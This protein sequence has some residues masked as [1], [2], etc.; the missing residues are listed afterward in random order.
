M[1][2]KYIFHENPDFCKKVYKKKTFVKR[3]FAKIRRIFA[4]RE[5]PKTLF[6]SNLFQAV[7]RHNLGRS[8]SSEIILVYIKQKYAALLVWPREHYFQKKALII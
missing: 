1:F 4:F 2:G 7:T 8:L 3:N 5:N 6:V